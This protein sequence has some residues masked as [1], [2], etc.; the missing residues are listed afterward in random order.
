MARQVL[1]VIGA[2]V[3]FWFGPQFA[4]WGPALG[5]QLRGARPAA[6]VVTEAPR[7]PRRR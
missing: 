6:V 1:P 7:E 5:S 2:A 4:S 3:G